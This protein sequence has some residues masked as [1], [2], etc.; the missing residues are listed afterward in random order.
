MSNPHPILGNGQHVGV[1][2]LVLAAALLSIELWEDP[3]HP[4]PG[5]SLGLCEPAQSSSMSSEEI[6]QQARFPNMIP[7]YPKYFQTQTNYLRNLPAGIAQFAFGAS[8][9]PVQV[10]KQFPEMYVGK[11]YVT[12]ETAGFKRTMRIPRDGNNLHD[13]AES[14]TAY[15]RATQDLTV[16]LLSVSKFSSQSLLHF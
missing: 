3:T 6:Q 2:A 10:Q 5:K 16:S 13:L 15:T 14:L 4:T 12:F 8:A 7:K 1:A 9:V 11:N